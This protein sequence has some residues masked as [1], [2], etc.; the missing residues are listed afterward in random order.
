MYG[1]KIV[2]NKKDTIIMYIKERDKQEKFADYL[3]YAMDD[4]RS[5]IRKISYEIS[6][7]NV[8]L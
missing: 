1:I 5:D 6:N 4:K 2:R 8:D 3:I 7:K